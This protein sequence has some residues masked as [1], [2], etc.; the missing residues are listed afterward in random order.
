MKW[1]E[2]AISMAQ[3]IQVEHFF[4]ANDGSH[5]PY[6]KTMQETERLIMVHLRGPID[7]STLPIVFMDVKSKLSRYLNKHILIDFKD[8]TH[9][10]S[11][12]VANLI[13]LLKELQHRDRKLALTYVSSELEDYI[14]IEKVRSLIH[15][16]ENEEEAIRALD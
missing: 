9:V 12:T 5:F 10:D 16:Y 15:I 3:N 7:S 8:V 1:M 2:E 14:V 13:F 4:R 11:A 6:V